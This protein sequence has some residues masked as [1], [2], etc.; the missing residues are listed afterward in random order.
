MAPESWSCSAWFLPKCMVRVRVE[1][2]QPDYKVCF[3]YLHRSTITDIPLLDDVDYKSLIAAIESW[4]VRNHLTI[5][6][7][8]AT[9]YLY[10]QQ[11]LYKFATS[12][13]KSIIGQRKK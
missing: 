5:I 2:W 7:S 4:M 8:I 6:I 1:L 10:I 13:I 3:S 12:L 11:N 9:V